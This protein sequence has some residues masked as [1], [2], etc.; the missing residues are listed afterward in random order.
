MA[1]VLGLNEGWSGAD[2]PQFKVEGQFQPLRDSVNRGDSESPPALLPSGP[3]L[4]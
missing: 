3:V 1:S 4:F 2:Q